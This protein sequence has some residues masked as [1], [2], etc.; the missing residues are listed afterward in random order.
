MK[1]AKNCYGC[2]GV[3]TPENVD[4]GN[5]CF[6]KVCM[7]EGVRVPLPEGKYTA[8]ELKGTWAAA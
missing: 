4:K 5:P 2:G 8:A 3:I 6:H 1:A 7:S